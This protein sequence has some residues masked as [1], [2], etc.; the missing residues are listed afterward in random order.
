MDGRAIAACAEKELQC[1]T[2][3]QTQPAPA[4]LAGPITPPSVVGAAAPASAEVTPTPNAT[5]A[6]VIPAP[7]P[8]AAPGTVAGSL[9]NHEADDAM[10]AYARGLGVDLGQATP[11]A[12]P[13]PAPAPAP[14]AAPATETPAEKLARLKA[15]T[16][17]LEKTLAPEGTPAPVAGERPVQDP[18]RPVLITPT[19]DNPLVNLRTAEHLDLTERAARGL[20]E[21]AITHRNDGGELPLAV[22]QLVED[23]EAARLGR[24]PVKLTAPPVITADA[25]PQIELATAQ[26]LGTHVA[27]RRQVL[28]GQAQALDAIRRDTPEFLDQAKETGQLYARVGQLYPQLA[29]LPEWP[30]IARD[31][32]TGFLANRPKPAGA[33]PVQTPAPA[34]PVLTVLPPP[35]A[36]DAQGRQVPIAPGAPIGGLAV[37]GRPISQKALDEAEARL[38]AGTASD[39]DL[40]ILSA[41][42]V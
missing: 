26:M 30:F 36:P 13:V 37:S 10:L 4:I 18:V 21:W 15:E 22:A 24:E 32:V 23:A 5:A 42:A 38:N 29:G 6:T 20:Q 19:A 9:L 28:A 34:A 8:A 16:A 7:A 3:M 33:A 35:T 39:A 31:L 41:A 11:A 14:P 17:A 25:V 27:Q 12:E 1:D 40:T 2:R